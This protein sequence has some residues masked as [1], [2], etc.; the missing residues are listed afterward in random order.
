MKNILVTGAA[1]YIGSITT[2]LLLGKGYTVVAL[3]NLSKGH[4]EAIEYL[5]K[6]HGKKKIKLYQLDLRKDQL[7]QVFKE[8]DIH[9]ILHFAALLDVGESWKIPQEYITNNVC[10]TQNLVTAAM[11]NNV[12]KIVFSSS[13]V[14]YGDAQYVPMDEEHPIAPAA[15]PYGTTKQICEQ[16][17]SCYAKCKMLQ[18]VFLRYF[19]V[20]GA[21]DDSQLGDAKNPPHSLVQNCIRGALGIQ[22]F[23][24]NFTPVKTPDGSPIRDYVNVVDLGLAHIKALEYMDKHPGK[25]NVFNLGTGTGNSVLEIVNTVKKISSMDFPVAESADRRPGEATK[26]IANITKAKKLLG[27][28]PKH[29]LED[30]VTTLVRWYSKHP[31]G[32]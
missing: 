11:L 3:D 17:L 12:R 18:Y 5:Q 25:S 22:K 14:V 30:S 21:A 10:G 29:T 26:M 1:G 13:G 23:E 19:N 16:I 7:D 15:S 6:K 28:E 24:L 31:R 4:P 9:A 20:C 2:D 27:W 8:N 32:W